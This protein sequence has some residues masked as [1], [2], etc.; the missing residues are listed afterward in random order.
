MPTVIPGQ[1]VPPAPD[2]RRAS[3]AGLPQEIGD[4]IA[5]S[6]EPAID[7]PQARGGLSRD[8]KAKLSIVARKV[9]DKHK[10][11]CLIDEGVSYDDWRRDECLAATGGRVGGFREARQR[12]YR[13][14]RGHFANLN[15]DGATAINDAIHG[16]PEE[17]DRDQA[18]AILGRECRRRGHSFPEY[19]ASI[20]ATQYRC[21]IAEASTK[22]IWSLIYT[23]RN[24]R[25][26][27]TL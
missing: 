16:D 25:K 8:Q 6:V 23:V 4:E 26:K 5:G 24:R 12:D 1:S 15:G 9:Y 10:G 13:H 7:A 3:V 21:P 2:R 11:L 19:P 27:N 17:A 20:C 18:W 22:Q 14:L